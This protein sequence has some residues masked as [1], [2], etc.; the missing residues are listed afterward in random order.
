MCDHR[1]PAGTPLFIPCWAY[2]LIRAQLRE[3]GLPDT[4]EQVEAEAGHAIALYE[5]SPT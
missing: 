5:E 4:H 3:R 1:T 2:N